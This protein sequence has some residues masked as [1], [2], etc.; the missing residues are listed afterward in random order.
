MIEVASVPPASDD[1]V[2]LGSPPPAAAG[3]A[4]MVETIGP[5]S[6]CPGAGSAGGGCAEAA[7]WADGASHVGS[8]EGCAAGAA[9]QVGAAGCDAGGS[10]Q[11]GA[12]TAGRSGA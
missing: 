8:A 2:P 12:A 6:R 9:S 7:G 4:M 3:Q 5:V 11:V 1:F 10:S